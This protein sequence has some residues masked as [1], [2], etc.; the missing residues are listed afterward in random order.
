[1]VSIGLRL[2]SGD[3]L[4]RSV[5]VRMVRDWATSPFTRINSARQALV[6]RDLLRAFGLTVTLSTAA[7]LTTVVSGK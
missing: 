6:G 4:E 7:T 5:A 1:M 3:T 2:G